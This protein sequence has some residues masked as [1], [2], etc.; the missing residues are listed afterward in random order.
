MASR[1]YLDLDVL[2]N[3]VDPMLKAHG[4]CVIKAD[5]TYW[6][7]DLASGD[8]LM[9]PKGEYCLAKVCQMPV[10]DFVA[11]FRDD[12]KFWEFLHWHE[13]GHAILDRIRAAYPDREVVLLAKVVGVAASGTLAWIRRELPEFHKAGRFAAVRD[14][15][16]IAGSSSL[17]FTDDN[18]LAADA[19]WRGDEIVLVP[20]HWNCC[21]DKRAGLAAGLAAGTWPERF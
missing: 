16:T 17:V 6:V 21:H 4:K 2:R 3:R 10:S 14:Y 20:R 12:D 7:R 13:D 5:N 1:I 19:A 11:P 8:Q 18:L 9:W 15:S